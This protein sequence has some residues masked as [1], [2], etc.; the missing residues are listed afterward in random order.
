M[1]DMGLAFV[2]CLSAIVAR[3]WLNGTA[4]PGWKGNSALT[5]HAVLPDGT[6]GPF[7]KLGDLRWGDRI[8]VHSYGT[9]YTYE[10]RENRTISPNNMT[11]FKHEENAWLTLITCKNYNEAAGTYAN[12]I[13]VRAVLI[14]V[15]QSPSNSNVR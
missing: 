8:I 7:A 5:S 3:G 9:A 13:A 4:F 11:V 12:R 6:P 10:V 14:R 15:G 1:L 2:E